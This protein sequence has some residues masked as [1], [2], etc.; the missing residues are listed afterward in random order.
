MSAFTVIKRDGREQV[1]CFD[2]ISKRIETICRAFELTKVCC[3]DVAMKTIAG[4]VNRIKTSELDELAATVAADMSIK[5]YDYSTL[6]AIITISN[7]QKNLKIFPSQNAFTNTEFLLRLEELKNNE[8]ISNE[9]YFL[10]LEHKEFIKTHIKY[11]RDYDYGYRGICH[12]FKSVLQRNQERVLESP[13]ELHMRVAFGIFQTDLENV[14]KTYEYTSQGFYTHATPTLLNAGTPF[15]SLSSCFLNSFGSASCKDVFETLKNCAIITENAGGLGLS[16]SNIPA[17][18]SML[19]DSTTASGL[20]DLLRQ[21]NFAVRYAQKG[22]AKRRGGLTAYVEPWHAEIFEF[23]SLK[24]NAGKEEERA[25]GLFYGLWVPDLFM[26]RVEDNGKWSLFCPHVAPGLYDCWGKEFEEL[27]KR[28]EFEG[29]ASKTINAQ[30]L[31][32]E[33]LNSQIET[34]GPSFMFK[35]EC[36]RVCNQQ[37]LGT[38]RC[39]NLCTEII[40]Y[41]SGDEV[42]VCNLA[43]VSLP[44]FI[45]N[46][47]FDHNK[48]FEVVAHIVVALNKVI[49]NTVYPVEAARK[50]NMRHRPMG[51]G[52]QGLADLFL[53]LGIAY[54][55][56]NASLLDY[57]DYKALKLNTEIYETIYFAAYRTSCNLAKIHGAHESFF[58]SPAYKGILHHMQYTD[59]IL[60]GRWNFEELRQDVLKYGLYNS[61]LTAQMPTA[62]TSITL[63]NNESFEPYISNFYSHKTI[64]GEYMVVNEELNKKLES[65]GLWTD[66]IKTAILRN[67]GSVQKIEAIPKETR[68]M[69]KTAWEVKVAIAIRFAQARKPF[70]DQSQSFNVYLE[71]PKKEFITTCHFKA[72]R[73]GLKTG[74]YYL[75]S[76]H[77][78]QAAKITTEYQKSDSSTPTTFS[79]TDSCSLNGSCGA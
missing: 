7:F 63:G 48:L 78:I 49:D 39:T 41:S 17:K 25:R 73:A 21:F 19:K 9:Y 66:E 28:F 68:E 8:N 34:S 23:L 18:G 1:V 69:F 53:K 6:A 35:D 36:N 54:M 14:L 24:K 61:L 47:E 75:R 22:G 26:K 37:H 45:V 13:Q 4:L 51:I 55:P 64:T 20:V 5:H 77:A 2:K 59:T 12:L 29:R 11:E 42:A 50:S 3:T 74:L 30:D 62:G 58:G 76:K 65:L 70:I 32:F 79:S 72:W 67:E 15:G 46:G 43:S 56:D 31:W 33:I 44:K 71:N 27:Y 10:A 52:A 57:K 60:S 40:Q 38:I 16:V